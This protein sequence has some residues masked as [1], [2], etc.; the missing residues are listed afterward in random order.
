MQT[1]TPVVSS[2]PSQYTRKSTE[3]VSYYLFALVILGNTMYGL[4]VLLKNPDRGQGEGSYVIHHLP[5][6][7]GSLGTL[8]LD[9]AVSFNSP[10]WWMVV[11]IVVF[12]TG[13]WGMG[14]IIIEH[15]G[16]SGVGVTVDVNINIWGGRIVFPWLLVFEPGGYGFKPLPDA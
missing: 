12:N 13:P 11:V 15:T 16:L 5:W 14:V 10:G 8:A 9:L 7:I 4:S 3:G 1:L 2:D 6:L